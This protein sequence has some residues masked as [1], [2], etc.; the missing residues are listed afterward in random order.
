MSLFLY[1]HKEPDDTETENLKCKRNNVVT[2]FDPE[3]LFLLP[4]KTF[5]PERRSCLQR[6]LEREGYSAKVRPSFSRPRPISVPTLCPDVRMTY[7][8]RFRSNCHCNNLVDSFWHSISQCWQL[9]RREIESIVY[10]YSAL[11]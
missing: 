6:A 9:C 10:A 11:R 8:H 4:V 3:Y 5:R 2:S 7:K 1:A